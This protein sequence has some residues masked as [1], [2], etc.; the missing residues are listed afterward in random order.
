MKKKIKI[1]VSTIALGILGS[2]LWEFIIRPLFLFL[3]GKVIPYILQFYGDHFYQKVPL[4][5]ES[6]SFRTYCFAMFAMALLVLIPPKF[7]D[8]M[9]HQPP[10][11]EKSF[12]FHFAY[13][14]LVCFIILYNA[15]IVASANGIARRTLR[16]IEIVS[17]YITDLEYKQLKSDFYI[18]DSKADYIALSEKLEQLMEDNLIDH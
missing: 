10:E 12:V 5:I 15:F 16:D 13:K 14:A 11:N 4:S 1:V 3:S 9:F 17:P 6:P 8:G 18:I 2:A 7:F